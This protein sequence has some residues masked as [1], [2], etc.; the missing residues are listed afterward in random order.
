M[1]TDD[2]LDDLE[3]EGGSTADLVAEVRRLYDQ[4]NEVGQR[5]TVAQQ[6]RN[7]AVKLYRTIC[8]VLENAK[9]GTP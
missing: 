1:Y 3:A 4:L 7:R 8:R 9:E 5:L 2:E 6:E